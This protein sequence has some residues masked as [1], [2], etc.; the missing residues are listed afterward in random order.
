[1][2]KYIELEAAI[3]AA[4]EPTIYDLTDVPE[5]LS[6]LP[7]ADVVPVVHG[8]WIYHECVASCDGAISGYS[9]SE[10]NAF[11]DEEIFDMDE[12]HNDF[13]GNCGARMDGDTNG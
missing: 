9:C 3:Q 6:S 8:R 2:P 10:C 12:F 11:V 13:C 4:K 7:T 5:W 1:M